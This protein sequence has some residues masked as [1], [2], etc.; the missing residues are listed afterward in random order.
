MNNLIKKI[1]ILCF[2]L[3]LF[4]C[5]SSNSFDIKELMME[6]EYIIIDVRTK[7]EYEI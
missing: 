1:V 2:S 4:G 6:N 7:E 5:S 3:I